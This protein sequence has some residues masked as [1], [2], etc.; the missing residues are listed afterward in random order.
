MTSKNKLKKL[1]TIWL[2][3]VINDKVRIRQVGSGKFGENQFYQTYNISSD[4]DSWYGKSARLYINTHE[5][6]N[7]NVTFF[8]IGFDGEV[9]ETKWDNYGE[10]IVYPNGETEWLG[11]SKPG[12]T[13]ISYKHFSNEDIIKLKDM[14][15]NADKTIADYLEKHPKFDMDEAHAI[16]ITDVI[17]KEYNNIEIRFVANNRIFNSKNKLYVGFEIVDENENEQNHVFKITE[18]HILIRHRHEYEYVATFHGY[19]RPTEEEIINA[20]FRW[21]VSEDV[22]KT[23]NRE[24]KKLRKKC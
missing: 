15:D 14:I 20:I 13:V 16:Y 18:K 1:I 9:G 4:D 19:V 10:L 21:V 24:A 8:A 11:G 23:A 5:D 3:E 22:I 12:D 17:F 7:K 2:K 6:I